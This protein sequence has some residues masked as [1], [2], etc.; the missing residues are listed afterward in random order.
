[1]RGIELFF[2][3]I[4]YILGLLLGGLL[5]YLSTPDHTDPDRVCASVK[6]GATWSGNKC[7]ILQPLKE[8]PHE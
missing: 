1:M 6:E 2:P 5:V 3:L 8:G 4:S 7:V